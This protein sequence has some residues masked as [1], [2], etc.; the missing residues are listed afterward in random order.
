M[1]AGSFSLSLSLF[2]LSLSFEKR[3]PFSISVS[4]FFGSRAIFGQII[5]QNAPRVALHGYPKGERERRRERE[6]DRERERDI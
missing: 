5:F 4:L 6:N 3:S 2:S 1:M